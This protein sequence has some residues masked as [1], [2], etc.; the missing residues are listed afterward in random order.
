M[1]RKFLQ[2]KTKEEK[3]KDLK[4]SKR[5]I[6]NRVKKEFEEIDPLTFQKRK[7]NFRVE[8]DK[9]Q[10]ADEKIKDEIGVARHQTRTTNQ[11]QKLMNAYMEER[12]KKIQDIRSAKS[13]FDKDIAALSGE[14]SDEEFEQSPFDKLDFEELELILQT[15]EQ[16]QKNA[17]IKIHEYKQEILKAENSISEFKKMRE[18]L[19]TI[20]LKRKSQGG[21]ISPS[22][23]L[24]IEQKINSLKSSD[25][26]Q[27]PTRE[28]V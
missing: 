16:N 5:K 12:I 24:E 14:G 2:K 9:V 27:E 20:I 28:D 10:S 21:F 26:L 7:L 18:R 11:F 15:F 17:E 25:E 1:T 6:P 3:E 19:E 4:S 22:D 8:F 13:Q 23:E